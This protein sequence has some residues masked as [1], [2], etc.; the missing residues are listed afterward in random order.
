MGLIFP[1]RSDMVTRFPVCRI[2]LLLGLFF[3]DVAPAR[4]CEPFGWGAFFLLLFGELGLSSDFPMT[5]SFSLGFA[6]LDVGLG[7]CGFR[8]T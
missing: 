7:L 8:I 4:S 3:S 2:L 5:T 1:N 6:S